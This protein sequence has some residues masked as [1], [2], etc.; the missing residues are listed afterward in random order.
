M[1]LTLDATSIDALLL[2]GAVLGG[3]GGGSLEDGRYWARLALER[4]HPQLVPVDELPLDA[5]VATVSAVGAPAARNRYTMPADFVRAVEL[6]QE[7]LDARLGGLITSENGGAASANGLLQSAV[8][9]LPVVD[10]PCNGRAHPTGVMGSMGLGR[11]PD[12]V[13]RQTAV[14]GDPALGRHLELFVAA[15]LA[16]ADALVRLA[17]VE[18]GGMVAVARNPVRLD[19]VRTHGAPGA[20]TLALRVGERMRAERARGGHA[21]A[22][23]VIGELGGTVLETGDV[24]GLRL[25]TCGGYDV[26]CCQVG[27]LELTF[28]NEFMTAGRGGARLATFPDLIATLDAD[29]GMPIASAELV[30]RQPVI[31]LSVPRTRLILGAGVR[32]PDNLRAIEDALGVAI[33]E[34]AC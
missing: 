14:G 28:W 12:F 21:V 33:V 8:L 18:A 20:L 2:G 16:C 13:S 19:Y 1:A 17:A 4:G 15:S 32:D 31:V 26:G 30:T 11:V 25:N 24:A 7:R 29:T 6:L 10:A 34:D 22:E 3:G 9:G 5:L 23:A 27:S